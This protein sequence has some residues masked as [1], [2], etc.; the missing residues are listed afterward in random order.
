MSEVVLVVLSRP[1]TAGGILS[2]ARR[3]AD[4]AGGARLNV[5]AVREH[6]G[7][8]PL[9]VEV[10]IS[11]ADAALENQRRERIRVLALKAAFDG[12][13][14]ELEAGAGT[15]RWIEAEG[16]VVAIVGERGARAD[17]VTVGRPTEGDKLESQV[18]RA[19]L[20]ATDRPVLMVSRGCNAEFGRN[21]AVAWRND[22]PCARAIIPALRYL[23][24]AERVHVLIGLRTGAEGPTP[25]PVLQEHGVRAELHVLPL[26]SGPLGRTLLD[27]AHALAADLLVMGAYAHSPLRE[28]L[29]G[30]VTRYMIEHADIPVLMRH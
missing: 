14:A 6:S 26:G 18:F 1:E 29:L 17:V 12:W 24:A 16:S 9:A 20:F 22:K 27:T 21:I 28:L 5:L 25:P 3:L 8:S 7:V 4:L 2:A 13:A 23:A 30:G 10:L 19:A 11:E 15:P